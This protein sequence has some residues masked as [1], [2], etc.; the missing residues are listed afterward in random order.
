MSCASTRRTARRRSG[1]AGSS[2]SARCCGERREAV[3]VLLD[4]QGPRIRV[5]ALAGSAAPRARPDGH[6]CARGRAPG[7]ARFPRRTTISPPTCGSAPAFCSTTVCCR[8]R[9]TDLGRAGRG[10]GALRRRAQ[11]AQG[12]EPPRHRGERAGAHREGPGGRAAGGRD[13]AWTTSRSHSC[14]GRRTSSSSA[15]WCPAAPS[16]SPRSRRTRRSAISAAS[17]TRPTR[18]WWP[19]AIWASSCRSR[20]CR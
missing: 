20:K 19:A 7:R 8:S 3:A 4:L 6:L 11:G 17:S 9:S 14:A 10:A 1:R 18:S 15:R 13:R 2:S 12:D 16:S 5:G